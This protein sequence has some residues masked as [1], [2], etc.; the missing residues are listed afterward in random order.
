MGLISKVKWPP[1][2]SVF[3]L[4]MVAGVPL[5]GSLVTLI[6][7]LA[8][9]IALFLIWKQPHGFGLTPVATPVLLGFLAVLVSLTFSGLLAGDFQRFVLTIPMFS[10]FLYF[11]PL[12]FVL[13]VVLTG[14]DPLHVGRAALAGVGATT[15]AGFAQFALFPTD[16]LIPQAGKPLCLELATGNPLILAGCMMVLTLLAPLGF[17]QK[18]AFERVL[19][20]LVMACGFLTFAYLADGRGAALSFVVMLP[21]LLIFLCRSVGWKVWPAL[22]GAGVVVLVLVAVAW[23]N[24]AQYRN[25]AL[26]VR[27]A[28]IPQSY[29]HVMAGDMTHS[30]TSKRIAMYTAGVQAIKDAPILGHGPQNRFLAAKPYLPAEYNQNFTHLHNMVLTQW[31]AAGLIGVLALLGTLLSPLW[32]SFRSLRSAGN[33]D[34]RYMAIVVSLGPIL[35]GLTETIFFHDINSTFHLFNILLFTALVAH[36][37]TL[38][39][40]L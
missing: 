29:S 27:L 12:L 36:K 28:K 24:W 34:L 35:L 38:D 21:V 37:S 40:T 33:T 15:L 4:V 26:V 13:P 31:V 32:V 20:F 19:T 18:G 6:G 39:S 10:Q 1:V 2:W 3:V 16:C 23:T 7:A 22:A 11:I 17:S 5:L 14:L 9:L 25:T 30:S 8:S